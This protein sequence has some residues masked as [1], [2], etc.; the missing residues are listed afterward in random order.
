LS[1]SLLVSSCCSRARSL[2][3]FFTVS[4]RG[5]GYLFQQL[6]QFAAWDVVGFKLGISCICF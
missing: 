1:L 2:L 5:G 6:E 4:A 3:I